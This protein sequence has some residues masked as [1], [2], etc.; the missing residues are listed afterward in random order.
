MVTR[1]LGLAYLEE[2]KLAEAESEFR[3]QIELAPQEASGYANLAVTLLRTGR[4]RDAE[5]QVRKALSYEPDNPDIRLILAMI[6]QRSERPNEVTEILERS[7]QTEPA[8]ARTLYA[9]AE[10]YSGR[11]SGAEQAQRSA[12]L[13]RLV[14]LVPGNLAA[15]LQLVEALLRQGETDRAT[16]HLEQVKKQLPDLPGE[17]GTFLDRG[18]GFLRSGQSEKA[19]TAVTVLHNFLKVTPLYQAGLI[20]LRGPGGELVGLPILTLTA[21]VVPS[22]Q[23]QAS[24][25]A[26][27]RFTD[28]TSQVGLEIT[29]RGEEAPLRADEHSA[30]LAVADYD[31]DGDPDLYTTE[32]AQAGHEVVPLLFRNESGKFVEI[33]ASSGIK[34]RSPDSDAVFAD[35]DNDGY[36]DLFV[37]SKS[38]CMLYHNDGVGH[39]QNV[40]SS[41]GLASSQGANSGLFADLDHEGDLDLYVTRAGENLFHRNHSAG[42]FAEAARE[43]GLAGE[44]TV[45]RD[46]VFADFDDDGDLDLFVVNETANSVLYSNL[47]QGRFEDITSESGLSSITGG[48]AAAVGDYDNNGSP[49]LFVTGKGGTGHHLYRN[50]GDGTFALDAD[51]RDVF[52][53]LPEFEGLDAAFLDFDNDGF[54]DLLV[55]GKPLIGPGLFLLRN[56]GTGAFK[57]VPEVLPVS[58]MAVR[59]VALADYDNDGDLDIF[60]ADVDGGVRLLRN[61]GGNVNRHLKIQLVGLRKGSGKNNHFGV[62]AKVEIRAQEL[63]QSRTVTDDVTHFGLGQHNRAEVVRILWSNG[64]PQNVFFPESNQSLVEEQILKGSCAFLYTWDGSEFTFVKDLMWRSALGMPLGIMAGATAYAFPDASR[65][66]LKIPGEM[67]QPKGG[68]YLMQ[69]TEELWETAYFDEL[70]L[71]AVDHP[72]SIEMFVD[73]KFVPPPFPGLELFAVRAIKSPDSARDEHGT[74]LR[75]F[76]LKKDYLYASNLLAGAYQGLTR[77][78]DLILDP[79]LTT[80]PD[81]LLLFLNGWLFPTDAS[82]NVALAQSGQEGAVAPY[83]QV[84]NGDG[85]WQTVISSLGFPMG[86]DKTVIVDLS[87]K[88]LSDDLRVRVRTNM[89]VYWD[90]IFFATKVGASARRLTPLTAS[91]ADLH[92]RGFSRSFRKGGRYGPHW[93]DYVEVSTEPKWRDLIGNY[94]RYGDVLPLLAA[95]DDQYVII[96]S[97]DEMTIEFQAQ[98]LP[99]LA[100]GWSRDFMIYTVGWIKDGDLNTAYGKSVKPL[101]FHGMSAYP[102]GP[103]ESYPRDTVHQAYQDKYNT[104]KVTAEGLRRLVRDR[105]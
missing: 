71:V 5:Q 78:H 73:E 89:E 17:R 88:F 97:G 67:M 59:K 95:A 36:L 90:H 70:K 100:P 103:Q 46:A 52:R 47:R 79:G 96:N 51:A 4:Y 102:Y 63:Y 48:M 77:M 80:P 30:S 82:I 56:D 28:V 12:Y 44:K 42:S 65:E 74:D 32:W 76:I 20:D 34:H 21:I 13:E 94:T 38:G 55:A 1:S 49:D 86:K 84:L 101:P 23:K 22:P 93:F 87:G 27:L 41:A 61:D 37:A 25:L 8:H 92:H 98:H 6:L 24:V 62:G 16:M 60:T 31:R 7:L 2:S 66:W 10:L 75:P 39:F 105:K 99:P 104:R 83:L 69:I 9:L 33:G 81:S 43:T 45:S 64:V 68:S 15:R 53:N 85:K 91:S 54:L 50:Q 19:V 3:K 26:A 57:Q 18:L 14:D 29:G 35:F 58:S 40:T 72:D 11:R